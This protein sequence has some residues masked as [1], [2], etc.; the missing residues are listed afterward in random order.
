MY[1]NNIVMCQNIYLLYFKNYVLQIK[2][3]IPN[4]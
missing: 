3:D 1:D 2:S 4:K